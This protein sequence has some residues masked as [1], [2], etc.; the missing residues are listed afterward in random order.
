MTIPNKTSYYF[1]DVYTG[2]FFQE[3]EKEYEL[4]EDFP[5]FSRLIR[6]DSSPKI[7]DSSQNGSIVTVVGSNNFNILYHSSED[8]K[9]HS[10]Q[11]S[12]LFTSDDN[13]KI[14][15]ENPIINASIF[16]TFVS[17][18]IISQRK[19]YIKAKNKITLDIKENSYLNTPDMDMRNNILYFKSEDVP[20]QTFLPPIIKTFD[21]EEELNVDGSYP[22]V[23]NIVFSNVRLIPLD[24]LKNDGS[25]IL[26]ASA[27]FKVFYE[28]Q[29]G[30][31]MFSRSVP[32]SLSVEN[33][34]IDE[35][36]LIYYFLSVENQSEHL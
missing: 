28:S 32:I 26:N 11:I 8:E 17:C 36:T 6:I 9:I 13:I 22:P 16:C 10:V 23:E 27:I 21:F 19:F 4:G 2:N 25:V 29:N 18:K 12:E 31:V 5:D 20:M 1:R 15:S 30:Y 24:L 35:N 34:D 14:Q 7:K 3:W 33:E